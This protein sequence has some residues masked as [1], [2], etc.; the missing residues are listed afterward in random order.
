[1]ADQYNITN[2]DVEDRVVS[3]YVESKNT[4]TEIANSHGISRMTVYEI[5]RRRKVERNRDPGR[6]PLPPPPPETDI[7]SIDVE[8]IAAIARE[9]P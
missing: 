4:V 6:P 2:P 7:D 1:M 9:Y 3:A 8:T 5:L